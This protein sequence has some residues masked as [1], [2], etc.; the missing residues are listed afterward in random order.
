MSSVEPLKESLLP[1]FEAGRVVRQTTHFRVVMDYKPGLEKT[2]AGER[3]FIEPLSDKAEIMLGLAALAHN[4][5]VNNFNFREV[6]VGDIKTLRKSLRA[7]FI[8][9]NVASLFLGVTEIPKEGADTIPSPKRM[10]ECLA[11]HPDTYTFS[12]K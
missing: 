8:A 10:E 1:R 4:V 2:E 3:F 5:G 11:S 7:D 9:V 12:D 6:A